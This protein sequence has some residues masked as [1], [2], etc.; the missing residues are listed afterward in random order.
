MITFTTKLTIANFIFDLSTSEV[1]L[2]LLLNIN[3]LW[4]VSIVCL[5]YLH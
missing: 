2:N 1:A 3:S 5:A 4:L